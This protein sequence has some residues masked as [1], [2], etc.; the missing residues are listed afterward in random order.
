VRGA[1]ER[2]EGRVRTEKARR[3]RGVSGCIV[4]RDFVREVLVGLMID[5]RAL[6]V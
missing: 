3:A 2:V 4:C 5:V 6:E 1:D